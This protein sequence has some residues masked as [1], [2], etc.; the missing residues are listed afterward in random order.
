MV[1]L[2]C[3]S[4]LVVTIS[5]RRNDREEPAAINTTGKDAN[6][7]Q[8]SAQ[9]RPFMPPA[10]H[11]PAGRTRSLSRS[12]TRAD[13]ANATVTR[14]PGGPSSPQSESDS[15]SGAEPG[16]GRLH[17]LCPG[18]NKSFDTISSLRRHRNSWWMTNPSCRAAG[19]Q[20]K[21]PRTVRVHDADS[22]AVQDAIDRINEMMGDGT[23]R[24]VPP[25]AAL[26]FCLQ[27]RDE[28]LLGY[29]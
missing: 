20:L 19:S 28:V 3:F 24:G 9:A 6:L 10:G 7:Q 22:P 8:N 17:L 12:G 23:N 11:S 16:A 18:C 5:H 27:P 4:S 25:G 21:R 15:S 2:H 1:A 26:N 29:C 13:T 14:N